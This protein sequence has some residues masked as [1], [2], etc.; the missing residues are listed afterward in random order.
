MFWPGVASQTVSWATTYGQALTNSDLMDML[1][2]YSTAGVQGY[3]PFTAGGMAEYGGP[4]TPFSTGQ[5]ITRGTGKQGVQ[6]Q[7]LL[8]ATG[9]SI[10]DDSATIGEEIIAQIGAGV[11][12][13]PTYDAQG[14]PNTLYMVFFP[15]TSS[16]STSGA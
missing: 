7:T 3:C 5:T 9:N 2:Q 13:Q 6:L 11:L 10:T 16:R 8:V 4:A 12:P 15:Q 14:Y 1:S